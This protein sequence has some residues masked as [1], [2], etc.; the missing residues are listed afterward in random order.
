MFLPLTI[1]PPD[2]HCPLKKTY[3]MFP[4][5]NLKIIPLISTKMEAA[6]AAQIVTQMLL[7]WV[8]LIWHK[9]TKQHF[10]LRI[11]QNSSLFTPYKLSLQSYF[12]NKLLCL[13]HSLFF[14]LYPTVLASQDTR[15]KCKVLDCIITDELS[16]KT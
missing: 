11:N 6:Q 9:L 15:A 14:V 10:S 4:L 13:V 5:E 12:F 2:S 16:L 1:P 7:C 8:I 3:M